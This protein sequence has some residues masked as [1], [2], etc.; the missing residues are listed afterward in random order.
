MARVTNENLHALCEYLLSAIRTSPYICAGTVA[1][2]WR[3]AKDKKREKGQKRR[4]T[5]LSL[6]VANQPELAVR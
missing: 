6:Y 5:G 4:M 1:K 2:S 3:T